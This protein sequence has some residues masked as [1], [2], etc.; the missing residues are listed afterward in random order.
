MKKFTNDN[1]LQKT[2]HF[3]LLLLIVGFASC[4]NSKQST[5][6]GNM[7]L[8]SVV[9]TTGMIADLAQNLL[10]DSFEVIAL[11]GP[12]VDPHLYKAKASDLKALRN[13]DL[14]LYNGLHLEGRMSESL[15]HF[16]KEKEVYAIS[17]A[18]EHLSLIAL[19]GGTGHDPHI[20]FDISLWATACNGLTGKLASLF[21]TYAKQIENNGVQYYSQLVE[22]HSD[23]DSILKEIP[24]E[25]KVMVTAHDAFSYFG[26][27]YNIEVQALQ[28]ISTAAEYGV[29]DITDMSN[30][31]IER[32]VPAIFVESSIPAR[33]V[34][35]VI[36]ACKRKGHNVELGGTL[37]SDAMGDKDS[38]E[39]NYIG[40][41]LHNVTTIANALK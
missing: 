36:D 32:S 31:L 28:G 23:I 3:V 25:R 33:S 11:M 41:V 34:E 19:P 26:Q 20:W 37:Y 10:P 14:I 16:G 8:I 13:A 15:E 21:P 35:A 12:G 1:M 2:I 38:P 40:M 27:A 30:M 6:N 4:D 17:D 9:C 5:E 39:G 24:E 29:K 7:D 22:L 18:L